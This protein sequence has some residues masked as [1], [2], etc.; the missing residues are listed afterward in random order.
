MSRS[1]RS[2]RSSPSSSTSNAADGRNRT[3]SPSF[4]TRTSG[5]TRVTSPHDKRL[6][7]GM[8]VAGISRPAEVRRSPFSEARTTSRS[9]VS[10]ISG[11]SAVFF[12]RGPRVLRIV[13]DA[14]GAVLVP[15]A[16]S[17]GV[18]TSR[19]YEPAATMSGR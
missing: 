12:P 19:V 2:T 15:C 7:A 9:P 8:A 4:A 3:R 6:G 14:F 11:V 18:G 10:L 5:P 1:R 16:R 17:F 13:V